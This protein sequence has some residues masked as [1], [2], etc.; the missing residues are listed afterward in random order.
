MSPK[1]TVKKNTRYSPQYVP[2]SKPVSKI[3]VIIAI[4]VAAL[5]VLGAFLFFTNQFVGKAIEVQ[6]EKDTQ[7]GQGEMCSSGQCV[8]DPSKTYCGDGQVQDPNSYGETEKCDGSD[9]GGYTCADSGY[10]SP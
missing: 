9:L 4:T 5:V 6:C 7:C 2:A 1:D 8:A 10:I 3:F